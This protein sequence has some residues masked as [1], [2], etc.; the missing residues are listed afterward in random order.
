M[1]S[2]SFI[3]MKKKI[4]SLKSEFNQDKSGINLILSYPNPANIGNKFNKEIEQYL[5]ITWIYGLNANKL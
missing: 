3:W 1:W 4:S 5:I 2:C